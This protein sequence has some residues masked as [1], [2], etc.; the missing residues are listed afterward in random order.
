MKNKVIFYNAGHG[1][2]DPDTNEYTTAPSKMFKHP[3]FTFYEGVKN[4]E[5]A[6][7]AIS[8]MVRRGITVVPVFHPYLDTPLWKRAKIINDYHR[9]IQPG[10]LFEEHSN[11][12]KS[13]KARGFGIWTSPG[14][15]KSDIIAEKGMEL[16]SKAFKGE[17]KIRRQLKD[18]DS[19]YEARLKMLVDTLPPAILFENLFF[20]NEFD[21][22]KLRDKKYLNKYTTF[23]ADLAEWAVQQ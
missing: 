22:K 7:Q 3:K 16:Y 8:K 6:Y 1:D 20:D 11:A 17:T 21:V 10:I 14:Q 19:D 9:F 13:H 15:T 18:G 12:C 4:R 2:I 23:Q 5:V